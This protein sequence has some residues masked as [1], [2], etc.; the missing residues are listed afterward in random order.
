MGFFAS[1]GIGIT[2]IFILFALAIAT[3][4]LWQRE[5]GR[6]LSWVIGVPL[7]LF[8]SACIY[9]EGFRLF[10]FLWFFCDLLGNRCFG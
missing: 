7:C 5:W 3:D 9:S 2:L 4:W 10:V 8:I 1:L 6:T